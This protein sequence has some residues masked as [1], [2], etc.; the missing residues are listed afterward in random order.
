MFTLITST[1]MCSA[2]HADVHRMHDASFC[3][4]NGY[5]KVYAFDKICYNSQNAANI[6]FNTS[7]TL[8]SNENV[9]LSL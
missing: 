8:S 3:M 9:K 6:Q 7:V 4:F 1:L 5:I 2:K